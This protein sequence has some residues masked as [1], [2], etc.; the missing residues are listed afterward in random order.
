M[1][2]ASEAVAVIGILGAALL[3]GNYLAPYIVRV[4]NGEATRL[5]RFLDP[6]EKRIYRL[7][8]VDTGATMGWRQYFLAALFVNVTQMAIAFAILML[9]GSLPLNPQGY[10]GLSWDLSLNTVVSFATNTN[11]QHYA[12]EV[13]LSY[14]SQMSAIQFLQFTSAATGIC[15]LV[16][17]VRG[18]R[19]GS[20]HMGNFYVDFVRSLTRI[21]LPLCFV[22]ALVFVA[23]GI[24]QSLGGYSTVNTI[25]GVPQV[26]YAGPVASLVSIMQLGTN[27]G[28]YFGA[29]SAYPFQNPNPA[30]D[31]LEIYLMLLLPTALVFVF[32]RLLGKLRETRP[33][34]VATYGLFAIDLIIAFVPSLPSVGPG[35]ETRF[36]GF[37]STFWTVVTTA[38]TTGSV[39]ASLSGINPLGVVSAFFGMFI[40]ATPGG[41]GVGVMYMVM[42]IIITVFIVGL[43]TGRTPEYLGLKINARDVKLVMVAFLIHPIIILVPT[44][45]AYATN[46]VGAIPGFSSLPSSAGFTQVLYEFTTAAANNGSD[47]FGATANTPFFNVATAVVILLGRYGP[48][49]ILLALSGSMIGRKRSSEPSLKTESKTFSLVL[50]GSI[51]LLVVLTFFP[52][53]ILGPLLAYFQGMVNFFG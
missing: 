28:G 38:V 11:L 1:I 40:Q 37:F 45:L 22:A 15:A 52:F 51:L 35:L 8:G 33:I 29:N 20:T 4:Y 31:V 14:F 10:P 41:K 12:G 3:S 27:G 26:V 16:A 7:T 50:I 9:Q 25:E 21:L 6:V 17:M 49:A 2:G 46:A 30:T 44:V 34:L 24:P 42:Y 39:N 36:G 5:D 32:G 13:T 53:L 23:L 43:M 18:L 19:V 47:F 48:I